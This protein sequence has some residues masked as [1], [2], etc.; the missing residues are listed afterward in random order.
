VRT[1]P[2]KPRGGTHTAS[3]P[4][5]PTGASPGADDILSR[6]R[7]ASRYMI[8]FCRSA[9]IVP[10]QLE[11]LSSRFCNIVHSLLG[12]SDRSALAA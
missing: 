7:A 9:P 10:R 3:P 4:T 8:P 6:H 11:M 5:W 2:L 12:A 1:L